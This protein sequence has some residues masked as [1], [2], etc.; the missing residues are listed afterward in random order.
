[1]Y[2]NTYSQE[3]MEKNVHDAY[4]SMLAM[5]KTCTMTNNI[6]TLQNSKEDFDK[7]E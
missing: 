3:L 4:D 2:G 1:M 5:L 7:P 6:H